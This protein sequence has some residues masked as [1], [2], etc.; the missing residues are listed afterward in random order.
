VKGKHVLCEYIINVVNIPLKMLRFSMITTKGRVTIPAEKGMVKVLELA[1][2]WG[3]D[4]VRDS[5]GTKFSDEIINMWFDVYSTLCLVREDNE[6][7]R[8]NR[9]CLQQIYLL[10][11]PA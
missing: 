2:K 9:D 8:A 6:L 11:E 4:A 7:A 10:S 1:R 5:D 3:I